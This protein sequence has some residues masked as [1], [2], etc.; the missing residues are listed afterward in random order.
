VNARGYNGASV[1][2]GEGGSD[3]GTPMTFTLTAP[4]KAASNGSKPKFDVDV[5][6]RAGATDMRNPGE[7]K[8]A[9]GRTGVVRLRIR[10]HTLAVRPQRASDVVR[11]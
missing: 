8:P 7:W 5:V 9:W 3:V 2:P 4:Q 1:D 10:M 6:S 11:F